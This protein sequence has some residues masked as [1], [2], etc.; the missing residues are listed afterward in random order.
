[1]V[2]GWMSHLEKSTIALEDELI[3]MDK[4]IEKFMDNIK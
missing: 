2:M 4:G 1:M 3:K